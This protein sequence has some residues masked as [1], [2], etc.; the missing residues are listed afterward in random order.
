MNAGNEKF[1]KDE[2]FYDFFF[3]FAWAGRM[4]WEV[5]GSRKLILVTQTWSI[6]LLGKNDESKKCEKGIDIM[7]GENNW[8]N[9]ML[10]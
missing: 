8:L 6:D 2:W 5:M 10:G 9:L 1:S 7:F 3:L 4:S